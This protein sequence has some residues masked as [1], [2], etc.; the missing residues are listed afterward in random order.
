[1]KTIRLD[2]LGDDYDT[3]ENYTDEMIYRGG[4]YWDLDDEAV[5]VDPP[6]G[7]DAVVIIPLAVFTCVRFIAERT[8]LDNLELYDKAAIRGALRWQLNEVCQMP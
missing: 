4:N 3:S 1:M 8:A 7:N 6:V 2:P 5:V